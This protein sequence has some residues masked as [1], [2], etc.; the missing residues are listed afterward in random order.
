MWITNLKF[1]DHNHCWGKLTFLG[2]LP[3]KNYGIMGFSKGAIVEPPQ[4]SLDAFLLLLMCFGIKEYDLNC[5]ISWPSFK[6]RWVSSNLRKLHFLRL[7]RGVPLGT[8]PLCQ[9]TIIL[10]VS[11]FTQLLVLVWIAQLIFVCCFFNAVQYFDLWLIR[12]FQ[13]SVALL[14]LFTVC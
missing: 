10:S 1:S 2:T 5:W 7:G 12:N 3:T 6:M 11:T 9:G 13:L 4:L 14:A 8:L